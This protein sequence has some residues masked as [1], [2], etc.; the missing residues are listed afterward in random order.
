MYLIFAR[1]T[2]ILSLLTE[3]NDEISRSY[4]GRD[5]RQRDDFSD[6]IIAFFNSAF[7][8]DGTVA[9]YQ[10]DVHAALM[11]ASSH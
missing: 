4:N 6:E 7:G 10:L 2:Y 8:D 9:R 3:R 5:R 1:Y 11:T